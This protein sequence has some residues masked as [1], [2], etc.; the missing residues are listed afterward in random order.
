MDLKNR[1]LLMGAFCLYCLVLLWLLFGRKIG[2]G[3]ISYMENIAG[4]ISLRPF[5][6]I[7]RQLRRCF[8]P[9]RPWLMRHSWINLTGNVLLF[10]PLGVFLPLLWEKLG[11]LWKVVLVTAGVMTLVEIMQVLTLL[12]RGDVDDVILN[13]AGAAL[14]YGVYKLLSRKR[15]M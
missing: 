3:E 6:T 13:V 14:G 12:G 7:L 15:E 10:L 11:R 8:D 5:Y 2:T 1:K 9:G 4:R